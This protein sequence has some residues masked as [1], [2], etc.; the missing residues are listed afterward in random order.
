MKVNNMLATISKGQQLTIP[1]S[2][3]DA[4][5]IDVGSKVDIQQKGNKIIITPIGE[6]LD[7]LFE[8][9]KHIKPKHNWTAEQMDTYTEK[10]LH[11][12]HR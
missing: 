7:V 2:I 1:S 9:A 6:D 3:R 4:L 8:E 5:G 12:I 10:M 11:E